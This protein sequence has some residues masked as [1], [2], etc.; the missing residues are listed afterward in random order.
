MKIGSKGLKGF[1]A[2][3]EESN[4]SSMNFEREF[5]NYGTTNPSPTK[6]KTVL[7]LKK[8]FVNKNGELIDEKSH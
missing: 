8:A 4:A 6:K 7:L 2:Y 3:R 1:D 5:R